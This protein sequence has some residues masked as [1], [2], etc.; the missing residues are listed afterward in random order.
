MTF[1]RLAA[2]AGFVFVLLSVTNGALLGAPPSP[3]ADLADVRRYAEGNEFAHKAALL[4]LVAALPFATVFFAG[5]VHRLRTSDTAHDEAWGIALLG[6]AI[7]AGA[8]AIVGST[9]YGMLIYRGGSGLDDSTLR[10]LKDGELIAY[11]AMGTSV[12]GV[13]ISAAG[14]TFAHHALPSWH[15][16]V[17]AIVAVVAAVGTLAMV[18]NTDEGALI[19]SIGTLSLGVWV[20]AT[21]VVLVRQPEGVRH[22]SAALSA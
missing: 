14:P 8:A 20:L 16:V 11:S 21:S 19:S 15:G 17:G 1:N 5:V 12:A 4:A 18:L 7:L 9:L 22:H 3:G 6:S 2:M 10:L 13:A